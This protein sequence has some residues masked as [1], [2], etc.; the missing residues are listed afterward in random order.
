MK[1]PTKYI[2]I[3]HVDGENFQIFKDLKITM[4]KCVAFRILF[5]RY[6][7]VDVVLGYLWMQSVGT[8]NFNVEK[9]FVK[10]WYKKKKIALQYMSLLPQTETE[11]A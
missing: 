7:C 9:K 4:D 6:G 1:V 2:Q 8:V 10:I 3:T 5:F 11:K